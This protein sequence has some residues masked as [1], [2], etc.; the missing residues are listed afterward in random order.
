[1]FSPFSPVDIRVVNRTQGLKAIDTMLSYTG[2]LCVAMSENMAARLNLRSFIEELLAR[3]D[4]FWLKDI[5]ANPSVADA[6]KALKALAGKKIDAML[7]IGGGS[8][9]DLGKAIAALHGLLDE[10]S[11]M[12][13]NIRKAIQ[14]KTYEKPRAIPFL[15]AMPTTAGTGS[16]VTRWATVWDSGMRQKLS[17]DSAAIFPKAAVIVPEFAM[18]M[19]PELTLSTGLDALSHAM[20]AFW[21][22]ARTPLSQ[23]L[24]LTAIEKIHACLP[25]AARPEHAPSLELRQEMSVGALIAGLSF[26]ITRTTACHAISYPLTMLYNLP[27]GTAAAMTL[28]S[29]MARNEAIVPEIQKIRAL[30]QADG[31]FARWIKSLTEP[32]CPLR[33]SA[34]GIARGDLP[35][36]T[37]LCFTAGRMDNNPV[38]FD[39]QDVLTILEECL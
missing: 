20:E 23:T 7:L 29:V 16:E 18:T 1:M 31:G 13:D 22:K 36:I 26:S 9:I 37:E 17:V 24:A 32:I 6:T 3:H 30:F 39:R 21:A 19:G 34:F 11:L 28:D 33:L 15:L 2:G 12:E 10:K 27:H 4:G 38:A 35:E 14:E 5:P 8:T 25:M